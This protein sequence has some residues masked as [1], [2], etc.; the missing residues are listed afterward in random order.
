MLLDGKSALITGAGR[1]I[2]QGIAAAFAA[3]G[4]RVAC[5]AR[6]RAELDETVSAIEDAGGSALALPADVTAPE[7]VEAMVR[8]AT[9]AFGKL[10]IL[11]NNAGYASF[12]PFMELSLE[13]WRRTLEVNLTGAFLCCQAVLPQMVERG[14]GRIIN[15]SSVSGLRPIINQSAYCASKHGLN[16]LTSTLALELREY[17]IR[18]HAICPGGVVTR[19][20]ERN[21][22]E[23]DKSGWMM[24]E[25]VAHTALYLASM[26]ER[27]TTDIVYLRRFGSKPLGG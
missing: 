2:G 23:R 19:L 3:Q 11:V 15:I 5:G 6:T 1:G 24:P 10:D 25:D 17:G 13:E 18:V 26:S 27:A 16:G 8:A 9:G 4:C 14:E 7:Q 22:P 12:K 20:S 21:M